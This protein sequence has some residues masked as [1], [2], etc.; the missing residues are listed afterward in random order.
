[1]PVRDRLHKLKG[2]GDIAHASQGACSN[3][4]VSQEQNYQAVLL[5]KSIHWVLAKLQQ[6][7]RSDHRHGTNKV[8]G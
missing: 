1:M 4:I 3:N 8:I 7:V 2:V 6:H 5:E